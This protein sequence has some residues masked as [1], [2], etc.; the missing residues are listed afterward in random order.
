MSTVAITGASGYVGSAIARCFRA[1][2]WQ[3]LELGRRRAQRFALGDDI[4]IDWSGIDALVHCAWDFH[5][6]D[7]ADAERVNIR[8]SVSLMESAYAADVRS[9]AFPADAESYH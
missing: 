9:G 8:G 1:H 7:W 5:V 6:R 3:V 4:T 2:G